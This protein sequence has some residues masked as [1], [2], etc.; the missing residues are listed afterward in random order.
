MAYKYAKGKVFRGD[1][2][3]EDDDQ[4]NT[5]ID[6]GSDDYIGLVA[7]GSSVL[8]V[9][10]SNVGIGTET[11]DYTLDVAGNAGFDEYLYHNGDTDT[12]I[13]LQDDNITIKAGN[14]NFIDLTEDASQ[15]KLVCNE[16]RSDVD[17]IVRSPSENLALYLNAGNEVFHINH[18]ESSFKTKIHSTNGEAITVN[19]SGV[20]LNE[21]GAAANDFRVES[22]S[23]THMLFVDAGNE[24]VGIG[25]SS[26]AST[27]G[28]DGSVG[29]KISSITG[30]SNTIGAT[31]TILMGSDDGVCA[32]QLPAAADC[33]G[34]IYIFK[35]L[36][37][38][39]CKV[40]SN[41]SEK[42]EN[43]TDDLE[44]ETQYDAYTIQSDG[45][46]WWILGEWYNG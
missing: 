39:A 12:F 3:N 17:F 11:P 45:T 36:G 10:G 29:A 23:N 16:G 41:G 27:L 5:Y 37:S 32:A 22:D 42:I 30:T 46:E 1:I 2:Y 13:R 38:A 26:P 20:I 4:R 35:R 24:T 31:Y 8:V 18:G 28:V 7:S 21:D 19:N 6:F 33:T 44:L 34:R 25:T 15:D 43:S 40:Q 14:I 9:S